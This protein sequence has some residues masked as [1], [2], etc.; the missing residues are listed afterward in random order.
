MKWEGLLG[1][2]WKVLVLACGFLSSQLMTPFRIVWTP[3]H[4]ATKQANRC[5]EV[6]T[7]APDKNNKGSTMSIKTERLYIAPQYESRMILGLL[8]LYF[9]NKRNYVRRRQNSKNKFPKKMAIVFHVFP[10]GLGTATCTIKLMPVSRSTA[11]FTKLW[12]NSCSIT[13]Q[14]HENLTSIC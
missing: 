13:G 10:R 1:V 14:K 3:V 11:S 6:Q 8:S 9:Q 2:A 5:S 12:R 4:N 7:D